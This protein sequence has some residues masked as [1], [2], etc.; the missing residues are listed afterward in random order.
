MPHLS[1]C[2]IR[3]LELLLPGPRL[4]KATEA[5]LARYCKSA[6]DSRGDK[7]VVRTERLPPEDFC[8]DAAQVCSSTN[9]TICDV[10]ENK[11]WGMRQEDWYNIRKVAD[12]EIFMCQN[13]AMG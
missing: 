7:R 4:S 5:T 3:P 8:F 12:N 10:V 11:M 1:Y 13:E 9:L 2:R 6:V